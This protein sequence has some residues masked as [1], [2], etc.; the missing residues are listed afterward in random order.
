MYTSWV[1]EIMPLTHKGDGRGPTPHNDCTPGNA[2]GVQG[3][4]IP[5][6]LHVASGEA[7]IQNGGSGGP[8]GPQ[9][10]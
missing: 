9:P 6:S 2:G 7:K 5:F 10:M 4:V 1:G 8:L 3:W